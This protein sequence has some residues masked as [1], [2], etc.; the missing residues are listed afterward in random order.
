MWQLM[1]VGFTIGCM[2]SFHCIGMCG[3]LSLA[4]P[5]HHLPKSHQALVPVLY[6]WGRVVTYSMLGLLCGLAGRTFHIAGLQQVLSVALG[7]ILLVS[8]TIVIATN[9]KM[10][11]RLLAPLY[12]FVYRR[13][14]VLLKRKSISGYFMIG[15]TNGLLPCGMVYLAL[16]FATSLPH[17]DESIAVMFAFGLGT[18]PAMLTVG[19]AGLS[20][21]ISLRQTIRRLT[22]LLILA[23][24]VLL[25]L[26]GLNLNIPFISPHVEAHA[27][28]IISCHE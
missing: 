28:S 17:I 7:A 26:R 14:L 5:V 8:A 2:S 13:M 27:G 22:P 12:D 3:P 4:L 18:V 16:A 23:S 25:V 21:S 11:P 9:Q 24:G 6:N 15:L 1:M 19:Y 20:V 10:Q